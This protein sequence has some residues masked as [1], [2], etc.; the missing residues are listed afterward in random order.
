MWVGE[1]QRV[2]GNRLNIP[3]LDLAGNWG[4]FTAST[5]T[6]VAQFQASVGLPAV[7]VVDTATWQALQQAQC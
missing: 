3:I 7:G 4:T 2:L 6:A 1:L 5:A